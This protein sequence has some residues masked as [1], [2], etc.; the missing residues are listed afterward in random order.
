MNERIVTF[1]NL[2]KND[3]FIEQIDFKVKSGEKSR[4]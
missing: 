3:I 4:L 1:K 2:S